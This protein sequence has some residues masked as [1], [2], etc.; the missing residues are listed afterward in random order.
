M[1]LVR[2]E[3][4]KSISNAAERMLRMLNAQEHKERISSMQEI[5]K[6]LGVSL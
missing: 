4:A 2:V 6:E 3:A 5:L 1:T